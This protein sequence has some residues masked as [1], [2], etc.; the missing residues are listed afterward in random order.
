MDAALIVNT[1]PQ[2]TTQ[3]ISQ[4][5]CLGSTA[6]FN[7]SA[8]GT[9]ISYQWRMGTVNLVEG[10]NISGTST[11]MLTINPTTLLDVAS[12]YNVLVSG[13]C[14]VA[15][16][17]VDAALIVNTPPQI[18]TEPISQTVCLGSTANF[19]V[20]A[21]GTNISYQWRIGTVNLV[22]GGNISGTSTSTLTMNPTTLLDVASN[23]NVLVSGTCST[24]VNSLDAALTITLIPSV[25]ISSDSVLC[26]G[27]DLQLTASF[28]DGATYAWTGPNDF[29]STFQSPTIPDAGQ[30]QSGTYFL[31]VTVLNCSSDI[32]SL[33]VN[34]VTCD[35]LDFF[36]PE[37]FSPNN[38]G[39]NDFFVIR[40]IQ[41]YPSND[42]VIY[43]R[44][45]DKLFEQHAYNNTWDG[46][47]SFGITFGTDLLPVGTYFYILHLNDGSD[48][49]KGTIYLNR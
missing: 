11:S 36:I 45:G 46:T 8:T 35:S 25:L 1:H 5:V 13:T 30:I 21:T 39:I 42:F 15:L 9:N 48:A 41:A 20:S 22:D 32:L 31:S 40:G 26:L 34:V 44:W 7:V 16:S 28:I 14:P 18:T 3:P 2:I 12:N 37:G 6:N 4:T 47:S 33:N 17:S 23:Y 49:I 43:S 10:G 29:S 24:P 19:N 38:D 27:S